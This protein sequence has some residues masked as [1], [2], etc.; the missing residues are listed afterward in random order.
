MPR[1]GADLA[2]HGVTIGA[3]DLLI[4]ATALA[5]GLAVITWDRRSFPKM[6][7]LDVEVC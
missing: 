6:P 3:H 2:Q 5:N 4:G 7:E 1:L